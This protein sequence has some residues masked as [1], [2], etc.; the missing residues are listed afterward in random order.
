M[1]DALDTFDSAVFKVA[2]R[3]KRGQNRDLDEER[4]RLDAAVRAMQ[5]RAATERFEYSCVINPFD[6]RLPRGV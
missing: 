5:R 2:E 3:M 4:D 6:D 1:V